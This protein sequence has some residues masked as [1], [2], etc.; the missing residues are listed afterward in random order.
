M[1]HLH[2]GI[3]NASSAES[4][5]AGQHAPWGDKISVP[6]ID[7]HLNPSG[8]YCLDQYDVTRLSSKFVITAS[9]RLTRNNMDQ[10]MQWSLDR[11]QTILMTDHGLHFGAQCALVW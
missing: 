4:S 9:P 6:G 11:E 8:Q 3:D 7:D 1:E 5:F 10:V 2:K